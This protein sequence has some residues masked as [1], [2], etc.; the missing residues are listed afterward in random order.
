MTYNRNL[1]NSALYNAGKDELGALT[2]SV[3]SAHTGPHIKAVIGSTGGVSLLSDFEIQEG[4]IVLP[5]T[6]F[7]F[8][9]LSARIKGTT[10]Q[11][12]NLPASIR[13]FAFADL[14]AKIFPSD[15]APPDLPARIFALLQKDLPAVILGKLAQ[16]DLPASITPIFADLAATMV[17]HFPANLEAKLTIQQPVNLGAMIHAPLDLAAIINFPPHDDLGGT[18]L[19]IAAPDLPASL[20]PTAN[21]P[22]IIG[23]IRIITAAISNL[24]AVLIG[25]DGEE[26]VT[27]DMP[28]TITVDRPDLIGLINPVRSRDLAARIN[29]GGIFEPGFPLDLPA[30]INMIGILSL[31]G[32]ISAKATNDNDR[33]LLA[34]IQN[35]DRIPD[36]GATIGVNSNLNNL[37][38]TLNSST[39]TANLP[40]ALTVA[41]T[42]V[43]SLVK[44]STLAARSLR[45][46][47]G[48]PTCVGGSGSSNLGVTLEGKIVGNLGASI[49]SFLN[50]DM[51]AGINTT[52]TFHAMDSI[53]F[54]FSP[55]RVRSQRFRAT[56]TISISFGPFRG[57]SL[58]ASIVAELPAALLP[59]R[60]VV[61]FPPPRVTPFVSSLSGTDLRPGISSDFEEL[62]FQLEGALTE[63]LYVNGT[64]DA[65]IR[66]ANEKW[67]INVRSFSAIATELFGETAAERVCR[68][69]DL[70]SFFTLDEAIR[71][72]ID[73]V[74]GIGGEANLGVV[75]RATGTKVDLLGTMQVTNI[76]E[77]LNARVD[78]VFASDPL[79]ATITAV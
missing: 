76:L 68:L 35:V 30:I 9:D 64:D 11:T 6:S 26:G 22:S 63:F 66:D 55:S 69:G 13:G 60:L 78:R 49:T 57:Q 1:Y 40:A 16:H 77:D 52:T 10:R 12:K 41:E 38:A 79:S 72:C 21:E 42:F 36:L 25:R 33:F 34:R 45:A 43:T 23:Y 71:A 7:K 73:S 17:G 47:I 20:F 74:F 14:A 19:G 51:S 65:F 4:T 8:P 67:K 29:D 62:R 50:L 2:R 28:A 39:S 58:G 24:P 32:T 59:A 53:V 44:V 3:I 75:I 56:D 18:M 54:T 31:P 5:P 61:V 27:G 37:A 46:T 48:S 70:T 15:P